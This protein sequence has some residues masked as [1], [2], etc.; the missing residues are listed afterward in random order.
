MNVRL[1]M[2]WTCV[3]KEYSARVEPNSLAKTPDHGEKS[4]GKEYEEIIYNIGIGGGDSR[5]M[6][7]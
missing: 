2:L 3:L 1:C 4:K 5:R 6:S 7:G